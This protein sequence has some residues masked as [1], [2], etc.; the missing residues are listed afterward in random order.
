MQV[1]ELS[2]KVYVISGCAR[3][4]ART[5][6]SCTKTVDRLMHGVDDIIVLPHA[7]IIVGTPDRDFALTVLESRGRLW[8]PSLVTV[9]VH[10]YAVPAFAVN[11]I[12]GVFKGLQMFHLL[13]SRYFVSLH[14]A[15]LSN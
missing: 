6:R 14:S 10:E 11:G 15:V 12:E 2:L 8:K 7:E 9:Q 5:A 4:V 1:S 13:R 3:N